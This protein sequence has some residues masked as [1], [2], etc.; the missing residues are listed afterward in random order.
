MGEPHRGKGKA[1]R[2]MNKPIVFNYKEYENALARINELEAENEQLRKDKTN[3]E[4]QCRILR[5]D[6]GKDG[7]TTN[8]NR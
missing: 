7:A 2:T 5:A 3:L 1:D 4:I 6:Y 8:T